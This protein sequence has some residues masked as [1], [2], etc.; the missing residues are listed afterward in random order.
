M[1]CEI[2]NRWFKNKR[3][4]TTHYSRM[5]KNTKNQEDVNIGF[6]MN[7]I[8]TFITSEIEKALKLVNFNKPVN[9]DNNKGIGIVPIKTAK[10]MPKFNILE[11]SKRLVVN[12]MKKIFIKDFHFRDYLKPI[13][14]INPIEEPTIPSVVMEVLA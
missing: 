5:H 2:C 10:K 8:K 1:K 4:Y 14:P 6:D 12:E 13:K 11:V 9:N 3:A 7:E